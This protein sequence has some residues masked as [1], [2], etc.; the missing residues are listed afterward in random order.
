[1]KFQL[2]FPYL[3]IIITR[4]YGA[5]ELVIGSVNTPLFFSF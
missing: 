1:M 2:V 4:S 5:S 3:L